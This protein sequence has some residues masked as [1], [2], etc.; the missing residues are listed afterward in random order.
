MP[1]CNADE[2]LFR[3][4]ML[5]RDNL[6][7]AASLRRRIFAGADSCEGVSFRLSILPQA[8]YCAEGRHLRPVSHRH[9]LAL[10]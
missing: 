7:G 1:D 9:L 8:D 10:A 6:S 2:G 4:M 3:P 5:M